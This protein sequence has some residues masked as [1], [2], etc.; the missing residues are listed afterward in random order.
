MV[1]IKA[2]AQRQSRVFPRESERIAHKIVKP[3]LQFIHAAIMPL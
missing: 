2:L 3:R 1:L